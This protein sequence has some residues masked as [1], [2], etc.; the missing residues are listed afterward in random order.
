MLFFVMDSIGNVPLFVS[1]LSH[2]APERR[3]R[4]VIRE[5]LIALLVLLVFLFAGPL[6]IDAL[7]VAEPALSISGGVILLLIAIK[8]IFPTGDNIF[9]DAP[10][11][12]PLVVPLAVPLTAGPAAMAMVLLLVA[13]EPHRILWLLLAVCVAWALTAAVLLLSLPLSKFL[14]KRGLVAIERLMGM[15]LTTIAVQMFLTGIDQF[16][17]Q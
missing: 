2:V 5:L 10:E 13:R 17:A 11:G 7:Q 4:V 1:V 15:I 14:G 9:G 6:I 12:E 3:L 8:M 16:L